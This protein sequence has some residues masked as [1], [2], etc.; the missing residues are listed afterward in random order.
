MWTELFGCTVNMFGDI[1][2]CSVFDVEI[3]MI[4]HRTINKIVHMQIQALQSVCSVLHIYSWLYR[5][6]WSKL[7]SSLQ[8]DLFS[9]GYVIL[10]GRIPL[11]NLIFYAAWGH[12]QIATN[13]FHWL[14]CH[15]WREVAAFASYSYVRVSGNS[16]Q[17]SIPAEL[18]LLSVVLLSTHFHMYDTILHNYIHFTIYSYVIVLGRSKGK[19]APNLFPGIR[20]INH[21]FII[22]TLNVNYN[23]GLYM[24]M[25]YVC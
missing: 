5:I 25:P 18:N 23:S 21:V 1:I 6:I 11:C 22:S 24:Y 2:K 10:L 17:M 9:R 13:I 7:Y 14:W 12:I 15:G 3:N 4:A 20:W 16:W 19:N 8:V